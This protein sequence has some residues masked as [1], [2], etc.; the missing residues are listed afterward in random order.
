MARYT[1]TGTGPSP[2]LL[3][4]VLLL[5]RVALVCL[6]VVL[7]VLSWPKAAGAHSGAV[8]TIHGDGRG[9]VWVVAQY[10]DGHPITEPAGAVLT[11]T[12]TSTGQ[13]IGPVALRQ[14]GDGAG[15]LA[16]GGS[17]PSGE[18]QVVAELAS[19]VLGRCSATLRVAAAGASAAPQQV[20]CGPA[21]EA[22]AGSP[23]SAGALLWLAVG[24][25][26]L[27]L[28]AGGLALFARR[29][30]GPTVSGRKRRR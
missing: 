7:V 21:P 24:V 27:V 13:R 15:T 25:G 9:S 22:A 30:A 17:L 10:Q 3:L 11:A 19:P 29:K 16:Y 4:P 5:Q 14:R 1:R 20:R 23:S 12:S 6:V 18:W 28:A 26:V 8:L 2:V